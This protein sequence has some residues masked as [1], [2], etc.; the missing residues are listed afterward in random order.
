ML[1]EMWLAA[2]TLSRTPALALVCILALAVG[3]GANTAIFSLLNA[4]V[5]R[6]LPY[7]DP[8]RIVLVAERTSTGE[9]NAVAAAN[10]LD[11]AAQSTSFQALAAIRG[12]R[13]AIGVRERPEKVPAIR[14]SEEFFEV[15]GVTPALGRNFA[16]AEF[17]PGGPPAVILSHSVWQRRF[18]SDPSLAGRTIQ[19]NDREFMVVGVL[20]AEFRFFRPFEVVLPLALSSA[21]AVRDF[22]DL[23]VIGRLKQHVTLEQAGAEMRAIATNIARL[24]PK[25]KQ[26]WSASVEG[27]HQRLSN[28]PRSDLPLMLGASAFVL[29][30]ACANVAGMLL[31]RAAARSK[32]MAV[33]VALGAGRWQ[34]VRQMISE[35]LLLALPAG[36]LGV[37]LTAWIVQLIE[38]VIPVRLL[39]VSGAIGID[40]RVL[41]FTLVLSVLTSLLFGLIPAW[42][43]SKVDLSGGL[44]QGSRG[45]PGQARA[46]FRSALT[47]AEVALSFVLISG[48]G[49]LLRSLANAGMAQV[50]LDASSVLTMRVELPPERFNSPEL[51]RA[52]HEDALQRLSALPDVE[53]AGFST[54]L[55]MRGWAI[56]M[57]FDIVEHTTQAESKRPA[58]HFQIVTPAYHRTMGIKLCRGRAFSGDD[59]PGSTRVAIVNE[60]FARRYMPG[61]DP[62]GK[63][64][65]VQELRPG[66]RELG[67]WLT[68]EIVGVVNALGRGDVDRRSPEIYVPQA[69]SPFQDGYYSLRTAV[70]PV[71]LSE[72]S[73]H[74]VSEVD[75]S[76]WTGEVRTM[77][78]IRSES[79]AVPRILSSLIG[80]FGAL[81]MLLAMMGIYGLMSWQVA[82]RTQEIGI[83]TALGAT[84]ADVM[85]MI[86]KQGL[87]LVSLGLALGLAGALAAGPLLRSLLV[88]VGPH[89]PASLIV[90]IVLLLGTA[91]LAAFPPARRAARIDPL[92]AL[93]E[94]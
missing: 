45:A 39:P 93:R 47:V 76:A 33:R 55:P 37:A 50:G 86:L 41:A 60:S 94:M 20:P 48:A 69:Q 66:T 24:H 54:Q 63:H 12:E 19:L 58:A 27:L 23:L 35:S 29:L 57:P 8:D 71:T 25:E 68:W 87:S 52:F 91:A 32:E 31:G 16:G 88:G 82:Q 56:G 40:G 77:E 78:Q 28:G 5:V 72:T 26:G 83:R 53:A 49:L 44:A 36:V 46:R 62:L 74:V 42:S 79:F 18:G 43:A 7:P 9:S 75:K 59:T 73:Q 21:N 4:Y 70:D 81:A 10:F 34:L 17:E 15:L 22:H 80:A 90:A 92:A 84:S 64:L 65:R 3:I 1:A 85:R 38:R 2:R 51:I 61:E 6:P 30:I 11:W 67:P 89:D 14:V 13:V